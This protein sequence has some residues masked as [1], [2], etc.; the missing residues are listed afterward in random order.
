MFEKGRTHV[1]FV[2][3]TSTEDPTPSLPPQRKS[4]DDPQ[5]WLSETVVLVGCV[6]VSEHTG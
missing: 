2:R 5:C 3:T 6:G 4:W 1:R